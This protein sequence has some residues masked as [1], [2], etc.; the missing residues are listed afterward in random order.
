MAGNVI[1]IL[2]KAKDQASSVIDGVGKAVSGFGAVALGAAGIAGG[3][4]LGAGTA[5]AKLAVDAAPLETIG[6][7]FKATADDSEALI[8]AFKENSA[9]AITNREAMTS[10]NEA[11]QLV[12][13]EFAD[14]L[15]GAMGFL[16]KVAASTGQDVG[17]MLSS[18][19]TGVGRLSPQILDNLGIQVDLTQANK[20]WAASM[21]IAVEDMT[22]T[23]QQAAAMDQVM[24][25]LSQNTAGLP[26]VNGTAAASMA[27]LKA[28][29]TDAKDEIGLALVPLLGELVGWFAEILP[30]AI[31]IL[32]TWVSGTLV[33]ALT[34]MW[35]WIQINLFP[36]FETFRLWLAENLP[37]AIAI[38]QAW[39]TNT[40]LPALVQ[41]WGWVTSTLFP[42]FAQLWAWLQVNLPV[43]LAALAMFWEQTLLPAIL[44]VWNW[45]ETVLIPGFILL[46]AWLQENIPIALEALGVF[47]TDTLLPAIETVWQFVQDD[48]IPMFEDIQTWLETN[49]PPI[50][51]ALATLWEDTLLPAIE[52][53]WKFL[54]DDMMPIWEALGEF[55]SVAFTLATT[56]LA[57][58]WEK[59]L[60][61]ALKAVGTW[62]KD[63]AFAIFGTFVTW[64]GKVSGGAD[65]LKTSIQAVADKIKAFTDK[66]KKIK[67]PSWMTPG[68]PTPLEIGLL[69]IS[70]AF[71]KIEKTDAFGGFSGGDVSFGRTGKAMGGVVIHNHFG[72]G[73][74]RSDQDI[75]RIAEL[76]ERTLRLRGEGVLA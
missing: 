52:A 36:L 71:S 74:V 1:D 24:K 7:A 34:A 57:G 67:I 62:I 58:L 56:A 48:L 49:I 46:V 66:L 25:L 45:V 61:P 68:S 75:R 65:G 35:E 22:K 42:L 9:G 47:W 12:G 28:T 26:E 70:K 50:L 16:G 10:Y 18:L 20:D 40:L 31:E 41:F 27:S 19:T 2:L 8:R 15:P 30:P 17:F 55:F 64:L 32:T 43:A 23:Q 39:W 14:K 29:F 59:T 53:V 37:V 11:A 73:A 76:Q 3:A 51:E 63:T 38:L 21:G 6:E 72:P 4:L 69:G 5:L 44:V 54:S 13:K 33:P 60:L